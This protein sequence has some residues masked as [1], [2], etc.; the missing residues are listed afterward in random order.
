M[1]TT[2]LLEVIRY[3]FYNGEEYVI[4]GEAQQADDGHDHC[5]CGNEDCA[6]EVTWNST[7]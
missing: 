2:I 4:L 3:F 6:E 5:D 1:G 7:S